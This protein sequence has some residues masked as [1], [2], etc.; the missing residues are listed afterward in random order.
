[1][2]L[3]N[4]K[5]FYEKKNETVF[6]LWSLKLCGHFFPQIEIEIFFPPSDSQKSEWE[7]EITQV[8]FHWNK[9]LNHETF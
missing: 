8:L 1:M 9:D 5:I 6:T 3:R 7:K 2:S 4:R